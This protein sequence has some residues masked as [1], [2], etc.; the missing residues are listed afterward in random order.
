[1]D[2]KLA[3]KLI[4]VFLPF[5]FWK[6]KSR[7]TTLIFSPMSNYIYALP[8]PPSFHDRLFTLHSSHHQTNKHKH[9]HT[10]ISSSMAVKVY[11]V[12]A[13]LFL[14]YFSIL[15]AMM[16]SALNCLCHYFFLFC[17]YLYFFSISNF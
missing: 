12:Y 8:S 4:K 17:V 7:N 16:V 13:F 10:P 5:W 9:K 14:S 11:I 1:M 3:P 15:S 6:N 2:N